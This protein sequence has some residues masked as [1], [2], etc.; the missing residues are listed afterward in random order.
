MR[1][2]PRASSLKSQSIKA[3][4]ILRSYVFKMAHLGGDHLETESA[5]GAADFT[6]HGSG[7]C[8]YFQ[9]D[10]V[11]SQDFYFGT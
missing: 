2:Y 3:K 11:L 7:A 1:V 5:V 9:A 4:T 10:L 8:L 6:R